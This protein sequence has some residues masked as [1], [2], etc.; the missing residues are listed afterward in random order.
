MYKV[1]IAGDNHAGAK[2]GLCPPKY[3]N[4]SNKA[5]SYASREMW[6]W[7]QAL[8]SREGHFKAIIHTGDGQD[9]KQRKSGNRGLWTA[10]INE[11]V[12]IAVESFQIV[13]CDKF[14][15]CRG[16][17]YHVSDGGMNS[18]DQMASELNATIV[19]K[20]EFLIG[21]EKFNVRHHQQSGR[22]PHTR[23]N[24]LSRSKMLEWLESTITYDDTPATFYVRGHMHIFEF[25]YNMFGKILVCP[26]LQLPMFG[27]FGDKKCEGVVEAGVVILEF[28]DDG[29]LL[30][31]PR[32]E[33]FSLKGLKPKPMVLI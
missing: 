5:I 7:W 3:I 26:A 33:R 12:D 2:N 19:N 21:K 20:G 30:R 23:G 27:E 8:N 25:Q 14:V 31:L 4:E 11:Q 13:D 6:E 17:E 16:S 18:E 22:L 1:L 9:G 24:G 10:D 29:T 15:M 32:W 28:E